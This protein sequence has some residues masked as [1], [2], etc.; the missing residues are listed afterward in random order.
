MSDRGSGG[1]TGGAIYGFGVVGAWVHFWQQADSALGYALAVL[2]GIVWPAF[3][4]YYGL[5]ALVP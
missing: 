1:A 5:G 3:I 2:E 4:V